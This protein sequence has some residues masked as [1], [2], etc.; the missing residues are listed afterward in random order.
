MSLKSPTSVQGFVTVQ[1]KDKNGNVVEERSGFNTWT[2]EGRQFLAE[3]MSLL[4]ANGVRRE[5]RIKYM[6]VGTGVQVESASVTSLVTPVTY[7]VGGSEFLAVVDTPVFP[8]SNS[9]TSITSVQFS[10]TYDFTELSGV[11]NV[12]ITEAGLFTDGDPA[13]NY[14]VGNAPTALVNSGSR[15]PM[16]YKTFKPL[17][18]TSDYQLRLVWEVRFV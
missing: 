14:A 1:L 5:D 18:K 17:T 8:G 9:N 6:G 13:S 15:T 12:V 11:S 16:A 3:V 4:A 7:D 2:L 10:K